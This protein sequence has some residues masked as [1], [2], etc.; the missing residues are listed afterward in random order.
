[1]RDFG[2]DTSSASWHAAHSS[3][4][5]AFP[6]VAAPRTTDFA[7]RL[8]N[9]SELLAQISKDGE[10]SAG[11]S[12][13]CMLTIFYSPNC[14]FSARMAP[15]ITMLTR[16]Y[17]RLRI[18]LSD[19]TFHSK[20]NSRYGIVGTPT[21]LLWVDGTAVSRMDEAPFSYKAFQNYVEKWTDLETEYM[22][23]E[24][25]ETSMPD[26]ISTFLEVFYFY[27]VPSARNCA[28]IFPVEGF[29]GLVYHKWF[30]F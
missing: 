21:V 29:V 6:F 13:N 15:Y 4:V 20:L 7:V 12:T 3:K 14:A 8:M 26:I 18:V 24:T 10:L 22:P 27:K 2:S 11:A 1:L 17:P 25:V 16:M 19:A 28:S 9:A 5:I 23:N 30:L